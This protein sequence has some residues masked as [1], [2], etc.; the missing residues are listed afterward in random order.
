MI[1]LKRKQQAGGTSEWTAWSNYSN[2]GDRS[3]NLPL[4]PS[5]RSGRAG[6]DAG[7]AGEKSGEAEE[8]ISFR[9]RFRGRL[10]NRRW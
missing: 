1:L 10:P 3:R 9:T 2:I 8:N 6:Y 7:N 4:S 5:C